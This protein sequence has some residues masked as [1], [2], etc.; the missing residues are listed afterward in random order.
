MDKGVRKFDVS[1][2]AQRAFR[3][4]LPTAFNLCPTAGVDQTVVRRFLED[5]ELHQVRTQLSK[6]LECADQAHAAVVQTFE[7]IRAEINTCNSSK[8]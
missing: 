8:C 5:A 4:C 1:A 2:K 7:R 3:I 6:S